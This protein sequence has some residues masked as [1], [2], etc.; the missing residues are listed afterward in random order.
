MKKTIFEVVFSEDDWVLRRQGRQPMARFS[1]REEAVER[2]R[3][4]CRAN[5]PST[6]KVG[7]R[8]L[9]ESGT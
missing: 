1:T 2:G 7:K 3:E 9:S 4:E 8:P 5:R 6:L